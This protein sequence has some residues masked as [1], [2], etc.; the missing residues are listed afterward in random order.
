MRQ[1]KY[2]KKKSVSFKLSKKYKTLNQNQINDLV[3]KTHEII[4]SLSS[5][6]QASEKYKILQSTISLVIEYRNQETQ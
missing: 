4:E 1:R 5:L 3:E 2:K 6:E